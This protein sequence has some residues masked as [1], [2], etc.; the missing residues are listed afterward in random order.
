MKRVFCMLFACLLCCCGFSALAVEEDAGAGAVDQGGTPSVTVAPLTLP[1]P[2]QVE[3]TLIDGNA[4]LGDSPAPEATPSPVHDDTTQAMLDRLEQLEANTE[5]IT[6]GVSSGVASVF[7]LDPEQFDREGLAGV[8]S[9]I[10]GEYTPR[11]YTTNTYIDGEI[12]TGLEIVPGLAGLD[13]H[14]IAGV[15]LFAIMLFC[16]FKLLGGIWS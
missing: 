3:L 6:P 4:A 11:T 9:S 14:W 12:V 2:L 7:A 8:V 5:G 16:L 1:Q 15:A 13:W 10:F